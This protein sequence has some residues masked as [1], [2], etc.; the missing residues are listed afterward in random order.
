LVVLSIDALV[1]VTVTVETV[2]SP[3]TV[4]TISAF[5]LPSTTEVATTLNV[6][7]VSVLATTKTPFVTVVPDA[8]VPSIVHLKACDAVPPVPATDATNVSVPPFATVGAAA[9]LVIDTATALIADPG[10]TTAVPNLVLST[11]D[12]AFTV[13]GVTVSPKAIINLP[14]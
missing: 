10:V 2:A 7:A 6:V 13:I 12:V 3:E 8:T 4:T 9:G 1:G 14:S 5:L 11:V